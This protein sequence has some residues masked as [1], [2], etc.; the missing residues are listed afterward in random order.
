MGRSNGDRALG[1]SISEICSSE[2]GDQSSG[3]L[4]ECASGKCEPEQFGSQISL[5]DWSSE[6][7]IV[8]GI[9]N[10]ENEVLRVQ[11]HNS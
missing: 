3:E 4:K 1:R 2:F 9:Q 6:K 7:L 5:E 8:F 10:S 11:Y